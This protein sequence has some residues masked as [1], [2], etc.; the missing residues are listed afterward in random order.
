MK[1]IVNLALSVVVRE[2]EDTLETYPYH[3]Y[4]QAFSIPEVRQRLIS[5]VLSR[6]PG[7]YAVID[8]PE[9][10]AIDTA[11]LYTCTEE[12]LHIE[13]LIQ[14]G[15]ERILQEDSDWI[16]HHIPQTVTPGCAASN[17]FG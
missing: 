6:I 15:I 11:C 17:W 16:E 14:H 12:K 10:T 5:Y 13:S 4:Q 8:D 7:H 9:E 3:P 2:I 1:T